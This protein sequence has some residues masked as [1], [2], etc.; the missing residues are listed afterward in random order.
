MPLQKLGIKLPTKLV[1]LVDAGEWIA[2]FNRKRLSCYEQQR[3][4]LFDSSTEEYAKVKLLARGMPEYQAKQ[5]DF[6]EDLRDW[7]IARAQPC[8]HVRL[9]PRAPDGTSPLDSLVSMKSI[10]NKFVSWLQTRLDYRPKYVWVI[11]PT[12]RGHCHIHMLFF[13]VEYLIQKDKVDSWWRKQG[14]GDESGVWMEGVIE[15]QKMLGY[16]IKYLLKETGSLGSMEWQ[17]L[18]TLTRRREYGVSNDLRTSVNAWKSRQEAR[19]S[20]DSES[21]GLTCIGLTNSKCWQAVGIFDI[22]LLDAFLGTGT[23]PGPPPMPD[24]EYFEPE[25]YKKARVDHPR[26]QLKPE[27][28]KD[29]I[30]EVISCRRSWF[31]HTGKSIEGNNYNV[32]LRARVNGAFEVHPSMLSHN[33]DRARVLLEEGLSPEEIRAKYPDLRDCLDLTMLRMSK[34]NS[35]T[36]DSPFLTSTSDFRLLSQ[37]RQLRKIRREEAR[38][39]EARHNNLGGG[40]GG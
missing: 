34:G 33:M 30:R 35:V 26:P 12:K 16:M 24:I 3:L 7:A 15:P 40:I 39:R 23:G 38:Q 8:V 21:D 28:L 14:L 4:L 6:F 25:K 36:E 13:G 20:Q 18:L 32:E 22:A 37:E 29:V 19:E 9:S 5:G 17:G 11:E 1:P 2:D 27:E 10:V 31:E